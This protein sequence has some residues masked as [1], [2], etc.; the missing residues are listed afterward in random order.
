VL[1]IS[2]ADYCVVA[3]KEGL[4]AFISTT[5]YSRMRFILQLMPLLTASPLPGHVISVYAGGFEDGTSLGELPIGCPPTSSYGVNSVRK[6][7]CFM[8]TFFFEELAEKHAG[9]LSLSHIFP[10]LVDGPTFYSTDMPAWFRF[11]WRLLKPLAWFYMTT[12]DVCGEVMLYLATSR[13]PAKGAIDEG[14]QNVVGGVEVAK[15]TKGEIGGGSYTLGERGD[16]QNKGVSYERVRK[17]DT[18]KQIW[19]HTME[20]FERIEKENAK[21]S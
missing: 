12:P 13:F 9:H 17:E 3:T 19:D 20:T 4:D 6:H 8:K 11:I 15:S 7:T 14:D 18:S 21:P 10:G 16:V 2:E 1:R 5:Y